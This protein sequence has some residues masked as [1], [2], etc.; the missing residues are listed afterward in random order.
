MMKLTSGHFPVGQSIFVRGLFGLTLLQIFMWSR[1]DKVD[2]RVTLFDDQNAPMADSDWIS[3]TGP[4]DPLNRYVQFEGFPS[5][6]DDTTLANC[7][8]VVKVVDSS[9]A[10]SGDLVG[11]AEIMLTVYRG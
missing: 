6:A 10:S 3:W 9:E 4:D 11:G 1:G 7:A 2:C 5:R 8:Y